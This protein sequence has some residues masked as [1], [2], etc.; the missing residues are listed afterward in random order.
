MMQ[1]VGR[2]VK[3]EGLKSRGIRDL[4]GLFGV[5]A[6]VLKVWGKACHLGGRGGVWAGVLKVELLDR[7]YSVRSWRSEPGEQRRPP[8]SALVRLGSQGFALG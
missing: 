1:L 7:G 5:C 3:Q 8:G 2:L 6:N 4:G